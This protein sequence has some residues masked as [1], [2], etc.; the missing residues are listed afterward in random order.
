MVDTKSHE[1]ALLKITTEF[2]KALISPPPPPK[3]IEQ[4]FTPSSP[5]IT[6]HGPPWANSRLPFL[7][8]TFTG[9]EGCIKYFT[10]LS[11]TL[12]ME[13]SEDSFPSEEGFIVSPTASGMVS[14]VGKGRFKSIKTGKGWDEQFIYRFS[15]FDEEG[16]I[17]HWEIWAD[18]LSAWVAVGGDSGVDQD[19]ELE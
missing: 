4:Y 9:K 18:P 16:K 17:G 19:K 6:E 11:E 1:K 14:V 10:V 5:R 12:A 8:K 2:C 3:L 15:G 7:G 13:M